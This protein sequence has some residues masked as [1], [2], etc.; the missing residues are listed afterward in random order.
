MTHTPFLDYQITTDFSTASAR[1]II[2]FLLYFFLFFRAST[3]KTYPMKAP[4]NDNATTKIV[5]GIAMANTLS[6]KNANI[7]WPWSTKG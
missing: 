4:N 2:V 5:A 7:G 6:G 3:H 1:S